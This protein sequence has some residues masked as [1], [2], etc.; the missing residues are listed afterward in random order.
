MPKYIIKWNTGYGDEFEVEEADS[1]EEAQKMA[2]DKWRE[3]IERDA[4]YDAVELTK[5]TADEYGIDFEEY[6]D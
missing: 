3:D 1:Q 4:D 6:A 5:D 2:Y